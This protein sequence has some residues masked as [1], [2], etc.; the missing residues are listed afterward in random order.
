MDFVIPGS[1]VGDSFRLEPLGPGHNDRDYEAWMSS[2]AHIKATQGFENS[3]WPSPMSISENLSDL[4]RHA[5]DFDGRQGFT[6]SIVDDEDVIGCLYI[7]PSK[8][9]THDADVKSWVR[10]SRAEMDV[11]IWRSVSRWLVEEWPFRNPLYA[12]REGDPGSADATG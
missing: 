8:W 6:Y 2:I 9:S 11:V 12:E 10:E 3:D 5:K 7:Y 1:F 4:V